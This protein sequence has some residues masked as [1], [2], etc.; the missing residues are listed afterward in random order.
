[1]YLKLLFKK[2]FAFAIEAKIEQG[3]V[4]WKLFNEHFPLPLSGVL[5][6]AMAAFFH[7]NSVRNKLNPVMTLH[8]FLQEMSQFED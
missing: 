1:M 5:S 8:L 7:I 3:K 6:F 4:K 2:K